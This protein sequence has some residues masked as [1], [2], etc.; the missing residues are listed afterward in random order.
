MIP[1][2]RQD[3]TEE[4]I[5]AVADTLRSDFLTQGPAIPSF[6]KAFAEYCGVKYAVAV[7]SATAGL[8]IACLALGLDKGGL[9]W[10]VPNTFVA[11]ANCALYCGAKVDFV[12]IDP[13][14]WNISIPALEQKLK[15]ANA[16]GNLPDILVPVHF[17]GQSCDMKSIY[18]LSQEYGFKVVE[19]A[20][21]CAG[22]SYKG[23]KIGNCEY[24]N[25]CVFSLHPVKI[26][27]SGEGGIIT[28]NSKEL[29]EKL[30]RLRTHGITRERDQM[31]VESHGPWYF[32]QIDLGYHYRMTDIHA[33]L[34]LSQLKRL[35]SYVLKRNVIAEKYHERLRNLPLQLPNTD[36]DC[37]SSWHLYVVRL[38]NDKKRSDVFALMRD[39][40]VGVNV[41][42]IPV[43]TQPYYQNLGFKPGQFPE[44]EKYYE[45]AITL[46]LYPTL[47][48]EELEHVCTSLEAA[49]G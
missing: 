21:H 15:E 43:H 1:Y 33:A 24:S 5:R 39:T 14:S 28:T 23:K 26:I 20:A 12:D 2:G 49:L 46:P 10:T 11:S 31:T 38:K 44:A 6:E 18:R 16:S 25:L 36:K 4:D 13:V 22:A 37:L 34:G 17:S 45:E 40:G 42:Y 47:K 48:D 35:D 3:I 19:D 27:T 9:L 29:Y 7:S 41:H 8:H 30:L 32:Q